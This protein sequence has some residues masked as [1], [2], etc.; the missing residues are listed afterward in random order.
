MAPSEHMSRAIALAARAR[1]STSP[2]PMVGAVVVGGD[3]VVGEGYHRLAGG[4]HAEVAA[5]R[6]AGAAA[7][8]ATMY[9][10]LEPCAHQ[11]RTGPCS[12]AVIAAGVSRVVVANQ[13]PYPGVSGRGL[14]R[15]RAAGIEVVVGDGADEARALNPRWLRAV[16]G[17]RPFVALKFAATLDGKTATRSGDSRWI[18]GERARAET[19]RLRGAYDAVLVG[20]RTVIADDPELNVRGSARP[21]GAA[22]TTRQPL[23]V[24]VDGRLRTDPTARVHSEGLGG[25]SLVL[26]GRP[27]AARLARFARHGVE[28]EV[29]DVAVPTGAELLEVLRRR[30]VSSVLV[31]GGGELAWSFV[32]D[33]LVDRVYAFYGALAIGGRAAPTPVGGEGFDLLAGALRLQVVNLRRLGPDVLIEAVAA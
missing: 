10:T 31:E 15:M 21:A 6:Q 18:T 33:G 30:G 12:E 13:D 8:G 17:R 4:P 26:A 27:A 20:A 11:G 24:V 14:D 7:R 25:G 16:A 23:R 5:L 19:H 9:V 2:N 22:A 28:V 29:A 32:R 3:R 1:H